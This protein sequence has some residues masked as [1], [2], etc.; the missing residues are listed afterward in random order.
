MIIDCPPI[1][2]DEGFDC[3]VFIV[4]RQTSLRRFAQPTTQRR[5]TYALRLI[6]SNDLI[7]VSPSDVNPRDGSYC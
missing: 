7:D 5:E 3:T 1:F 6:G 4:H 2:Q